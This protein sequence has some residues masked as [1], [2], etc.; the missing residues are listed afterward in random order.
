LCLGVDAIEGQLR[1]RVVGTEIED[2]FAMRRHGGAQSTT[3]FDD[4]PSL[5]RE[6]PSSKSRHP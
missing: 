4:C 5:P 3:S 1:E 6:R 2:L